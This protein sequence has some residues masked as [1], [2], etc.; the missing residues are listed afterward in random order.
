MTRTSTWRTIGVRRDAQPISFLR[1]PCRHSV[2]RDARVS[3]LF[4]ADEQEGGVLEGVPDVL[5][6]GGPDVPVDHAVVGRA[7]QV[8]H[9]AEHDLV[10]TDDRALLHLVTAL[11]R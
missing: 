10:D 6:E 5:D 4:E 11:Y 7:R 2:R 8:H 1:P 3:A 9:V